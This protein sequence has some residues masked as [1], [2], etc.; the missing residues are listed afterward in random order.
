M[1]VRK[2]QLELDMEQQTGSKDEKEYVKAVYCH[3][4][5]LTYIQTAPCSGRDG[6]LPAAGGSPNRTRHCRRSRLQCS[7][8]IGSYH[9]ADTLVLE[10]SVV[11]K[12][13]D[14]VWG[15]WRVPGIL[16]QGCTIRDR[17]LHTFKK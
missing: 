11:G 9:L 2:Q 8:A 7:P 17:G 1:Q 14:V 12:G 5:Y 16:Q 6:R 4:A 3:P 15:L 13:K 10:A